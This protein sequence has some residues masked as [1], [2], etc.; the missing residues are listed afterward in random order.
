MLIREEPHLVVSFCGGDADHHQ[1]RMYE[2][3]T[4]L[5][6]IDRL[7]TTGLL[8]IATGKIPSPRAP[9]PFVIR[10]SAM[11]E[12]SIDILAWLAPTAATAILP[13]VH[14]LY[15]T[16]ASHVLWR[17]MSGVL[18]RMAGREDEAND[19]IG[20][21]LGLLREVNA[22]RHIELMEWAKF[23]RVGAQ[24][25][26]PV[27]RSCH[28]AIVSSEEGETSIDTF[29]AEAIRANARD[30]LGP[31]ETMTLRMDGF[32]HHNRQLRVVDP[33]VPGRYVTA[34]VR[35]PAFDSAPNVYTEAATT[36]AQL[37]VMAKTARHKATGRIRALFILNSA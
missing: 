20:Q 35:D 28:E 21:L 12:G 22:Q 36:K 15:V 18:M 7:M 4:A 33:E 19:H 6:G 34:H 37:T 9:L 25:V 10:T 30:R 31:M 17:W 13:L 16:N 2:V 14:E 27:G 8:S 5:I 3:G 24:S 1:L 29:D 23:A 11:R 32:T 26:E